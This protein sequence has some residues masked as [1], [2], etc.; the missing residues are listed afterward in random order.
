MDVALGEHKPHTSCM[1][2]SSIKNHIGTGH[3]AHTDDVESL[4]RGI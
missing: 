3:D 1:N 2:E 4:D